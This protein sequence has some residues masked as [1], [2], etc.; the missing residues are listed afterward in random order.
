VVQQKNRICICED[1]CSYISV[2]TKLGVIHVV[3]VL[4]IT[5]SNSAC[6]LVKSCFSWSNRTKK[7]ELFE[8]S[9]ATSHKY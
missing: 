6:M 7:E 9:S 2:C 8:K 4:I 5:L 3:K 1:Y